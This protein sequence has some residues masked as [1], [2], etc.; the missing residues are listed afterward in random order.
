MFI[1]QH[2]GNSS[3]TCISKRKKQLLD[4]IILPLYLCVLMK[5]DSVTEGI[6]KMMNCNEQL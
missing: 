6:N 5:S 3:Y 2:I 4:I 1:D